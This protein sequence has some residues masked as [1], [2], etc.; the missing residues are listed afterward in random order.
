[1]ERYPERSVCTTGTHDTETLRQWWELDRELTQHFWNNEL[2]HP[3]EAPAEASTEICEQ[4]VRAHLDSPSLLCILPL[5]DWLAIDADL[6]LPDANG[7]R[8]N[9][10]ANPR[11]YWRYRMHLS[12]EELMEAGEFNAKVRELVAASNR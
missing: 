10:P 9:I 2:H 7:E 5:Q 1:M 3:G 4:I 8:I 6:R 12:I 11:H